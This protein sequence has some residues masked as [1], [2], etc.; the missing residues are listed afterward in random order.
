MT[1]VL[2][3]PP[4]VLKHLPA[5]IARTVLRFRAESFIALARQLSERRA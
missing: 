5:E 4:I 1:E 3:A 2:A